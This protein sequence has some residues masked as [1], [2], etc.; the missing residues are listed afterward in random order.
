MYPKEQKN[1][2]EDEKAAV[3]RHNPEA[4]AARGL[5][6]DSDFLEKVAEFNPE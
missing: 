1:P 4:A 5:W 3:A 2:T 6:G